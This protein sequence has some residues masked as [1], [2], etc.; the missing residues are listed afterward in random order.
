MTRAK[1]QRPPLPRFVLDDRGR[2]DAVRA[3]A[4]AKSR[5]RNVFY[6][7]RERSPCTVVA[8]ANLQRTTYLDAMRTM[9]EGAETAGYTRQRN[10][11]AIR[12]AEGDRRQC[13]E[14]AYQAAGLRQV[15]GATWLD[16]RGRQARENRT[17]IADVAQ[18]Y[19]NAICVTA[20]PFH[21]VAI[22]DGEV[23]DMW[24]SH[25]TRS[26]RPKT[27]LQVWVSVNA[28]TVDVAEVEEEQ[29]EEQRATTRGTDQVRCEAASMRREG[30]SYASIAAELDAASVGAVWN[31]VAKH[32]RGCDWC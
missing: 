27:I 31:W 20:S 2:L 8:L 30:M 11:G 1:T 6:F 18:R 12:D 16:R 9:R 4:V 29:V 3:G 15:E 25:E 7:E 14:A 32:G 21:A 17:T 19:D 5:A 10:P 26:G 24:S 23:R 13:W 22:V 28:S